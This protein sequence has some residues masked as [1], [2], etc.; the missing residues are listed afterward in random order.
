M[1]SSGPLAGII[2]TL[3]NQR[4]MYIFHFLIEKPHIRKMPGSMEAA[5]PEHD[6][7]A[8][9]EK[10]HIRL[11]ECGAPRDGGEGGAVNGG[12]A[13]APFRNLL[14]RVHAHGRKDISPAK[15]T[16][17]AK[18]LEGMGTY[19]YTDAPV[20]DGGLCCGETGMGG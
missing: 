12:G 17:E 18:L 16:H 2:A 4:M 11:A 20:T 19:S 3:M 10:R 14:R 8:A 7:S 6:R 9:K 1:L 15:Q 13:G 5:L